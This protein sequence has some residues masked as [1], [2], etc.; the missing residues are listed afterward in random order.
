M[1]YA[2]EF[3]KLQN[4]VKWRKIRAITPFRVIQAHRFWYQPKLMYDF[5]LVINTDLPSIL[6]PFWHTAF[7]RSKI[8]IFGYPC[9]VYLPRRRGFPW[10]DLRKIFLG[11]ERMA[12]VPNDVETLPKIS[13]GWVGCTSVTDD[14]QTDGWVAQKRLALCYRTTLS[15]PVCLS[16]TLV[17][18]CQ[19][20][21]WSTWN[22]AWW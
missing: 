4:S 1:Q 3:R 12:K 6:H 22:L 8:A 13:T 10:G 15:C 9:C 17:Y 21:G 19:T 7:D 20:V 16:V 11:C 5:L 18:C 2:P 14:R